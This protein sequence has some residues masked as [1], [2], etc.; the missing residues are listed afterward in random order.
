MVSLD[1]PSLDVGA[2]PPG[3]RPYST[4][5]FDWA[6]ALL[7]AT[8]GRYRVRRGVV[9][10]VAMLPGLVAERQ[11]QPTALLTMAKPTTEQLE[12]TVV[13]SM[14]FD[15]DLV[16]FLLSAASRYADPQCRRMFSICS[17]AEFDVQRALQSSGF[18][19]AAARPG[20]IDIAA[21]RSTRPLHREFAGLPMTDELEF[22]RLLPPT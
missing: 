2:E 10:D 20:A 1:R 17:N 7:G 14:P 21:D 11:G 4:A 8:G 16:G 18:R 13:A 22:E 3:L 15:D 12:V 19:L 5:D 6:V 9:I